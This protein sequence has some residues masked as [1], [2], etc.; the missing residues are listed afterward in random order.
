MKRKKN[1]PDK[2]S[3]AITEA[4]D[5]L[6]AQNKKATA[7]EGDGWVTVKEVY[8]K[9][10]AAGIITTVGTVRNGL[11]ALVNLGKY[12]KTKPLGRLYWYREL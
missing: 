11:E 10:K 1:K 5:H 2:K 6:I 8:E 3:D 4:F 7:P 12:E 9:Y